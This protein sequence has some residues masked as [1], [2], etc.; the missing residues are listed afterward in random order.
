[1]SEYYLNT[2]KNNIISC[3]CDFINS[4]N[5][6]FGKFDT[7]VKRITKIADMISTMEAFAG[8]EDVRI[9]G[10]ETIVLR[11]KNIVDITKKKHYDI[12]DHRKQEVRIT[13]TF[14]NV[15]ADRLLVANYS[16]ADLNS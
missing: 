7:F 11:Y 16:N 12:L 10:L 3:I 9:E 14:L 13:L 5:Y 6:I 4:E 8:L 15:T 2:I 1:M